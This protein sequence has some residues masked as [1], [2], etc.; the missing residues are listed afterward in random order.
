MLRV[1]R[2]WD[3]PL[4]REIPYRVARTVEVSRNLLEEK[5]DGGADRIR[6][7]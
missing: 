6:K 3:P 2:S 5:D 1:I 4:Q 7:N